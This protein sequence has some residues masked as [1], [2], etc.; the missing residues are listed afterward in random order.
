MTVK[1]QFNSQNARRYSVACCD[2]VVHLKTEAEVYAK[3]G[4]LDRADMIKNFLKK[5]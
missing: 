5:D 4:R 2:W 3:T 1:F